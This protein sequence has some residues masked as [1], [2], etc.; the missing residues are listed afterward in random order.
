MGNAG[1]FQWHGLLRRPATIDEN[2]GAGDEAR[3]VRA[4]EASQ[5]S[6]LF[7]LTPSPER[8][9]RQELLVG[10]G[11]VDDR[12]IHVGLERSGTDGI[13]RDALC[14][15]LLSQRTREPQQSRLG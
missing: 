14:R 5:R 2:I 8:Q 15:D 12:G 7:Q 1:T 9:A 10:L 11:V 4:Q 3:R 6:D 13:Y